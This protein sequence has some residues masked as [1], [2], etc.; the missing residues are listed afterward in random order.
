MPM[1]SVKRAA[2]LAT[3][4]ARLSMP[5]AIAGASLVATACFFGS[6]GPSNVSQGQQYASGDP[7]FDAFFDELYRAQVVL[8]K[9][10][11]RARLPRERAAQALGL[12]AQATADQIG[13]ALDKRA[14]QIAKGGAALRV[15]VANL[16]DPSGIPTAATSTN[17]N[18]ADAG[19]RT[20]VTTIAEVATAEASVLGEVRTA[21]ATIERLRQQAD[22]LEP[23]IGSTF[24][25]GGHKKKAEV[26][27]NLA[28]AR[29]LI[30]LMSLRATDVEKDSASLLRSMMKAAHHEPPPPPPPP[31]PA[32]ETGKKKKKTKGGA[33][34]APAAGGE[35][36]T[37]PAAPDYEP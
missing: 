8:G 4:I 15:T 30:P 26:E 5:A 13:E 10:P 18:P 17:T 29:K 16:D 2:S 27:K 35:T 12:T 20:L 28:D 14:E 1:R 11:D 34:A 33:A 19:D 36:K 23:N 9:A 24:R 25:K 3:V 31:P 32:E 21:R 22:I 37:A 6:P 7:G